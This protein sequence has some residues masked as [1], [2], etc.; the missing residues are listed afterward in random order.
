MIKNYFYSNKIA[1]KIQEILDREIP[2]DAAKNINTGDF[3]ILPP[4]EEL[5][6]YLPAIIIS[7]EEVD[8]VMANEA[9]EI[10]YYPYYFS[11]YYIYPYTFESFND[12]PSEARNN[13]ESIANVLMN[14]KTLENFMIEKS[15]KEVG[16]LILSS[17]ITKISFENIEN[18]FFRSL[19]IPASIGKISYVIGFRTFRR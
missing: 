11:I 3:G 4:P 12:V 6:K 19:K 9:L 1:D 15:E 14:H 5:E 17:S 7:I 16:G 8:P 18:E 2:G 13:I 10:Q